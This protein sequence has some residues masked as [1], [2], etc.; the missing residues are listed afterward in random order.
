MFVPPATSPGIFLSNYFSPHYL[1]FSFFTLCSANRKPIKKAN[2]TD[3]GLANADSLV[4]DTRRYRMGINAAA[5][6]LLS[7]FI[8]HTFCTNSINTPI[9]A[10]NPTNPHCP[11]IIGQYVSATN[12]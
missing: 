8:V 2:G 7:F 10:A 1:L 12:L 3:T 5:K 4:L 11:I 9:N 6:A